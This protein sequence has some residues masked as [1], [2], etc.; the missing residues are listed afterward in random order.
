MRTLKCSL[1]V[2]FWITSCLCFCSQMHFFLC[3]IICFHLLWLSCSKTLDSAYSK[4]MLEK[5]LQARA[6]SP[7]PRSS[8]PSMS[9]TRAPKGPST[10]SG[11]PLQKPAQA[12][13]AVRGEMSRGLSLNTTRAPAVIPT[14]EAVA[15]ICIR[16]RFS[17]PP[18]FFFHEDICSLIKLETTSGFFWQWCWGFLLCSN[19]TTKLIWK[20]RGA[21]GKTGSEV[22]SPLPQ[23]PAARSY[24]RLSPVISCWL[25]LR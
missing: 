11:Q 7:R 16:T 20:P 21:D 15:A 12:K 24:G 9:P 1:L 10:S 18:P 4:Q 5:Q 23:S 17:F 19:G 6:C 3:V 25:L 13:R 2:L 8:Q 22:Q 14:S